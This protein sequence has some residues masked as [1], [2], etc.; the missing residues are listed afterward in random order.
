MAILA[1][2]ADD[3]DGADA[4]DNDEL[5][6]MLAR[7][8]RE[9]ELFEEIDERQG[10]QDAV[11]KNAHRKSRLVQVSELPDDIANGEAKMHEVLTR[12]VQVGDFGRGNRVKERVSYADNLTEHEFALV[13]IC[14]V[15]FVIMCLCICVFFFCVCGSC[16]SLWVV[17]SWF[18]FTLCVHCVLVETGCRGGRH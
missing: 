18:G 14:V 4:L 11:W 13:R 17:G 16:G 1:E 5:N 9:V 10:M 15:V 3:D 2:V 8:E 7:S 12:P 6:Q